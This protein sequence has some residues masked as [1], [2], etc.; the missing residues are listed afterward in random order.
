[1]EVL[2]YGGGRQTVAICLLIAKGALPRPDR[3]VMADTGRENPMTWAYL[4]TYIQPLLEPLGMVVEIAPRS[5]STVD[6]HGHNGD[7][8]IPA[9]TETG[10]LSGFCSGEWKRDVSDRYLRQ[11][12]AKGGV[13]WLGYAFDEPKRWRKA[14]ESKPRGGWSIRFPLVDDLPLTTADCLTIIARHGWPEPWTSSCW[15]CPNKRNAEWR[16]IRDDY[17]ELWAKACEMDAELRADDIGEGHTGVYLHWS[18]V[19]LSQADLN[20]DDTKEISRQCALGM[21]FI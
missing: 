9:F 6:L 7:L 11:S 18:R 12:G 8:L 2:S 14:K 20:V 16:K 21:C 13:K 5:L 1:M 10:K 3:I 17:P 19:P 15:M 4:E